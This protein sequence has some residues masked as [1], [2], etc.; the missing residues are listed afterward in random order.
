MSITAKH[1]HKTIGKPPTRILH[2][3]SLEIKEGEFIS[4]TGRSG[5]GKSS[6]LYLL[7]GLDLPSSGSIV[8]DGHSL[9]TMSQHELCRFH[10]EKVGFVFQFHYLVAELNAL[11]NV[12]LPARKAG[13]TLSRLPHA[14]SLLEQFDLGKKMNRLPRQLSGG[15]QQRVAIARSLIM[16]PKYVFADEPTGALDTVNGELVMSIFRECN[17]KSGTTIILVTHD[18]GFASLA[19]RQIHMMDGKIT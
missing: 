5:S 1:V 17:A 11:E 7:S 4:L 18:P 2:D 14:Q 10:N 16:D 6:L 8:L 9:L 15:E 19:Q 12:L 3:I 13:Q